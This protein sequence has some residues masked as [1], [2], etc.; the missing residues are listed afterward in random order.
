MRA[1]LRLTKRGTV[2]IMGTN[3]PTKYVLDAL[4]RPAFYSARYSLLTNVE[5]WGETF[6]T[7]WESL[8][9]NR[10]LTWLL[11]LNH[12]LAIIALIEVF[13]LKK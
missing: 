5:L 4:M 13:I 1:V 12:T 10:K 9:V 7:E 3:R 6:W 2:K 11:F 8:P